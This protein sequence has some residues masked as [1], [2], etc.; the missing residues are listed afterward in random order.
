MLMVVVKE[1]DK[2]SEGSPPDDNI[3]GRWIE[4]G[5]DDGDGANVSGDI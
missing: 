1:E 5:R 4:G 2:G 3:V